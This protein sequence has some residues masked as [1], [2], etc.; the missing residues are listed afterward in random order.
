M[1]KHLLFVAALMVA[2][3]MY[4]KDDLL[5]VEEGSPTFWT[6]TGKLATIAI[7]WSSTSVVEWDGKHRVEKDFGT[8][9]QYNRKQGE[10]FVRDW[11]TLQESI[12]HSFTSSANYTNKKKGLKI[13]SPSSPIMIASLENMTDEQ[14]EAIKKDWAKQEQNKLAPVYYRDYSEAAYDIFIKVDTVDMGNAA[15]SA[16]AGAANPYAGGADIVGSMV[17]KDHAT[18]EVV[19]KMHLNHVKGRGSYSQAG[20]LSGIAYRLWGDAM[21][22]LIKDISKKK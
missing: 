5:I 3:T 1:K 15:A 18:Q 6:E 7:D 21:P 19:C 12:T 9:D 8:I 10:D 2:A 17:V 22:K 11:P 20:R 13:I 4:A 16:F 14:K